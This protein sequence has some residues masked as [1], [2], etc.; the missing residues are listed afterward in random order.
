MAE[1]GGGGGAKRDYTAAAARL[2]TLL[3]G[4]DVEKQLRAGG[5]V[6]LGPGPGLNDATLARW[7]AAEKG[8]AD[9]AA[10]RLVTHAR[11]RAGFVRCGLGSW[12]MGA[13]QAG[14][15]GPRAGGQELPRPRYPRF[16]AHPSPSPGAAP[17]NCAVPPA[18][19][20]AASLAWCVGRRGAGAGLAGVGRGPAHAAQSWCRKAVATPLPLPWPRLRPPD[21]KAQPT[22]D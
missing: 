3:Q 12:E 20:P 6:G 21:P 18:R 5:E 4:T 8:D 1:G 16:R 13:I 15:R 10:A 7:A 22:T 14:A 19:F 2:G 17:T 9:A 11:W